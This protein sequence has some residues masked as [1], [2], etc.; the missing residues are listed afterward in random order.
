[1]RKRWT[2]NELESKDK[3]EKLDEYTAGLISFPF[4]FFFFFSFFPSYFTNE[5]S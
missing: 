2:K 5:K 1:M 3:D 4:P